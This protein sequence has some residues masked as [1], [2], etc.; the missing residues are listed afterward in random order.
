MPPR[1]DWREASLKVSAKNG[2]GLPAVCQMRPQFYSAPGN[3]GSFSSKI[4]DFIDSWIDSDALEVLS[5]HQRSAIARCVGSVARG[6]GIY[7]LVQD[8]NLA[9][10]I[11]MA[12][13]RL[14]I[15]NKS[16]KESIF[17]KIL[18]IIFAL[19]LA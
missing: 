10:F 5:V 18:Y 17:N 14:L 16:I 2:D 13:V 19:Y 11:A 15:H 4:I 6:S 12:G 9:Q 1:I 3:G 8:L 7:I